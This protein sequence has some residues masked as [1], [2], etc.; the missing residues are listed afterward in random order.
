MGF[1][2]DLWQNPWDTLIRPRHAVHED[3]K[4]KLQFQTHKKVLSETI[5]GPPQ[6]VP[7]LFKDQ[8]IFG[9]IPTQEF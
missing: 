7:A 3:Q 9:R 2:I 5:L 6:V 4:Y 8:T 1:A